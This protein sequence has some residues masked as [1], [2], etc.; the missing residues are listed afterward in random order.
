VDP[1]RTTVNPLY[2]PV[3]RD[4]ICLFFSRED[5]RTSESFGTNNI[6]KRVS[7]ARILVVLHQGDEISNRYLFRSPYLSLSLQ[8]GFYE[9]GWIYYT[10]NDSI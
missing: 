5:E 3:G 1:I 10:S 7:N 8:P 2:N 6:N 9:R 4:Q